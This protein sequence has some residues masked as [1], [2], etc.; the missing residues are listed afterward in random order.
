Q[1]AH[2]RPQVA[3]RRQPRQVL[4][5]LNARRARGDGPELAADVVGGVG[6]EVE[7][8]LLGQAAGEEDVDDRAGRGVRGGGGAEGGE[9]VAAQAEQAHS[10]RWRGGARGEEGVLERLRGR[11]VHGAPWR[12]AGGPTLPL[13][14]QEPAPA[15]R[16]SDRG[17]ATSPASTP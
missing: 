6:L 12:A 15:A 14:Y 7:A 4:A 3:P 5:D 8:V 13:K 17:R 16:K 10:P 9:V 2:Q 1:R 11:L